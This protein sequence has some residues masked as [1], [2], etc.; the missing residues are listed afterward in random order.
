MICFYMKILKDVLLRGLEYYI[1]T[2]EDTN[3]HDL[4]SY[5]PRARKGD[6][7][8]YDL[9]AKLNKIWEKAYFTNKI[10]LQL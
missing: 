5:Q 4:P 7:P 2:K 9:L 3:C 8:R 6:L 10:L 1:L